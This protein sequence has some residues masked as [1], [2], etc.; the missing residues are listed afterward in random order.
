MNNIFHTG[1]EDRWHE[2]SLEEQMANVGW[3]DNAMEN[4]RKRSK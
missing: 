1:L 3:Q 2:F 4:E